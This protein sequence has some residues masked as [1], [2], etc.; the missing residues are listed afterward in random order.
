MVFISF[1]FVSCNKIKEEALI[2][3]S[4]YN[5]NASFKETMDT[6]PLDSISKDFITSQD[7]LLVEFQNTDFYDDIE[8]S[9][10]FSP[11]TDSCFI[12]S[13]AEYDDKLLHIP[14]QD[15]TNLYTYVLGIYVPD[16]SDYLEA[17]LVE[18]ST[19]D[20]IMTVSYFLPNN[21]KVLEGEFNLNNG[22]VLEVM[23]YSHPDAEPGCWEKCMKLAWEACQAD[24]QCAILCELVLP[25]CLAAMAIAC[26]YVCRGGD[27]PF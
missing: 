23:S 26:Y 8:L 13:F 3:K 5:L 14:L 6:Y 1:I 16:S 18:H 21:Y 2:D 11:T 25:E 27:E 15:T 19:S 20:S 4:G 24:W 17:Y 12:L 10:G 9:L 22:R 7:S